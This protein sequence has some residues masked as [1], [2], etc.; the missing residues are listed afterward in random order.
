MAGFSVIVGVV[1]TLIWVGWL[2]GVFTTFIPWYG[3][4]FI[5]VWAHIYWS[6]RLTVSYL[7]EDDEI[8]K[9][10]GNFFEQRRH[11]MI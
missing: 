5:V 3:Y 8:A 7:V 11:I 4:R 2:V 10:R 6:S 9:K 1:W